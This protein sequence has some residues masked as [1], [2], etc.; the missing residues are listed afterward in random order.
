MTLITLSELKTFMGVTDSSLD[1]ELTPYVN[2]I[3]AIVEQLTGRKLAKVTE[4][5]YYFSGDG[6][7]VVNLP[8]YPVSILHTFQYNDD[9]FGRGTWV[10]FDDSYRSLD[11]VTGIIYTNI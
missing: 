10:D 5:A 7:E 1:S 8:Y 2:S 9:D 6:S 4:Q 3:D 11:A